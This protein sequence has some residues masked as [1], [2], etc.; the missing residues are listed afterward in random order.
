MITEPNIKITPHNDS[1]TDSSTLKTFTIRVYGILMDS[2]N[3]VLV[4]DEFIRGNYFTKFPGGG[5]ELGEGT[6]DCLKREFKEETNLDVE[7]GEHI[8]TTDYYQPSAFNN[9]HQMVG[10][11]Y[12]VIAKEPI[13]LV[14]Q[15]TPFN[16]KPEQIAD[17]NGQCEVFRWIEWKN[18][19]QDDVDLPI[20][21][22]VVKKI[23]SDRCLALKRTGSL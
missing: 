8:Y 19:S 11:Y 18:L 6:I 22:I 12:F 20:D 21:K 16:F 14:T 10:I 1:I 4:S 5:M 15:T 3:R 23:K 7:I 2:K 9:T 17:P 13:N